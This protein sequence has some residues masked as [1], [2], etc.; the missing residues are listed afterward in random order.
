MTLEEAII[1]AEEVA[2]EYDH[3]VNVFQ[4]D[5]I[6]YKAVPSC[7]KCAAEHRQLA[8]WLRELKELREQK[9]MLE[10]FAYLE[11]CIEEAKSK[12]WADGIRF[13]LSYLESHCYTIKDDHCCWG[14]P[15]EDE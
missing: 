10:A 2:K 8:E 13:A 4:D 14:E 15:K 1:H 9:P 11:L 7:Q 6:L 3:K 12:A 5:Y